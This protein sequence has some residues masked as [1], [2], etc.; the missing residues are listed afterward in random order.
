MLHMQPRHLL[1]SR[2]SNSLGNP[3]TSY[4]L[5]SRH[6]SYSLARIQPTSRRSPTERNCT[7]ERD[8]TP[9]LSCGS[10]FSGWDAIPTESD[11]S[12]AICWVFGPARTARGCREDPRPQ[13]GSG[14]IRARPRP[15]RADLAIGGPR[16]R[17]V[18]LACSEARRHGLR[19]ASGCN[20]LRLRRARSA[21][22]RARQA[23]HQMRKDRP[24]APRAVAVVDRSVGLVNPLGIGLSRGLVGDKRA[25]VV[26]AR[27]L[28]ERHRLDRSSAGLPRSR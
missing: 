19:C 23:W 13:K 24:R 10:S 2:P 14:S 16:T 7:R 1:P 3:D 27:V 22:S 28:G 4:R 11:P 21:H 18:R 26:L 9:Y 12:S 25:V 8:E 15:P 20:R 5:P 6:H 17:R